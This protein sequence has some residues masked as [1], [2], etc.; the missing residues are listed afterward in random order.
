[1]EEVAG[2][3]TQLMDTIEHNFG[4]YIDFLCCICAFEARA[5][6]KETIDRMMD[7]VENFAQS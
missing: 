7:Y 6:D 3:H 1:M 2:M 5:K 4:K